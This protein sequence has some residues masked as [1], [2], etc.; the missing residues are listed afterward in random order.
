MNIPIPINAISQ[1]CLEFE[2]HIKAMGLPQTSPGKVAGRKIIAE[3]GGDVREMSK[4]TYVGQKSGSWGGGAMTLTYQKQPSRTN[5]T[6]ATF[7]F[8][9]PQPYSHLDI[10]SRNRWSIFKMAVESKYDPKDMVFRH[11]GPTGLKISVYVE[12]DS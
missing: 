4:H 5:L 7:V 2:V 10:N 9:H 12:N 8:Q 3:V 1:H 11:L 6:F